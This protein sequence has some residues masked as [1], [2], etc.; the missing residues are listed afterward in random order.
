MSKRITITIRDHI[1]NEYLANYK[2]NRSSFIE[3]MLVKGIKLELG[4][5]ENSSAKQVK[6]LQE[7]K[8]KE[9]E[10]NKLKLH[11]SSLQQKIDRKKLKDR[12][13]INPENGELY[14][15]TDEEYDKSN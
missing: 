7:M 15:M 8:V 9:E 10:I 2:G 4:D 14:Y 5:Y 12:T 6:L 13:Y 3:E 1:Y 11:I